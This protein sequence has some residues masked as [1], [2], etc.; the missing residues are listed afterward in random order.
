MTITFD[1]A[2]EAQALA[3]ELNAD[4]GRDVR[5][6]VERYGEKW[7]I[8]RQ[9]RRTYWGWDEFLTHRP[10]PAVQK[11][12]VETVRQIGLGTIISW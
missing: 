9:S 11:N 5:Y 4:A 10:K 3:A 1:I 12:D 2:S 6:Q 7:S 8:A